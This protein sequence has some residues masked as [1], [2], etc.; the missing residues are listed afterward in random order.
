MVRS[1]LYLRSP[2]PLADAAA[3]PFGG[4]SRGMY[5]LSIGR[6]V[7]LRDLDLKRV[8]WD[9]E[10][11]RE[12]IA[13]LNRRSAAGKRKKEPKLVGIPADGGSNDDPRRPDEKAA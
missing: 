6:V 5:H 1:R 8:I 12:V 7:K 11:R 13:F 2:P 4:P 9:V 3:G 10:Y